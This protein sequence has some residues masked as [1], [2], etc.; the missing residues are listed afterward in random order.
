MGLARV[1]WIRRILGLSLKTEKR[2]KT[3]ERL[4][5]VGFGRVPG[6]SC[7]KW[8]DWDWPNAADYEAVFLNCAGLW[9]LLNQWKQTHSEDPDRFPL[10]PFHR[11]SENLSSMKKQILDIIDSGR[12]VFALATPPTWFTIRSSRLYSKTVEVYDWCPL[13]VQ[14][15]YEEGQV[16]QDADEQFAEYRKQLKEWRFYFDYQPLEPLPWPQNELDPQY[17]YILVSRPLFHNLSLKALGIELKYRLVD[18][19][20]GPKPP[21]ATSGPIYLLH[22]PFGGDQSVALRSLVRNFCGVDLPE[23]QVPPWAPDVEAPRGC[24]LNQSIISLTSKIQELSEQRAELEEAKEQ[25]EEWRKLLYES[26]DALEGVVF[27]ALKLLG[28]ENVKFGPKADHDIAGDLDG[29]TLVFEVKGL[30]GPAGRKH[31][32]D[33]DRHITEFEKKTGEEDAKGVLVANAFRLDPPRGRDKEGRQVFN[34][35]AVQHAE[36]LHFALLDSRTLYAMVKDKLEGNLTDAT[37]ELRS[38]LTT[39]GI[40]RR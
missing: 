7:F 32:F 33:L 20:G 4:L 39:T 27:E 10:K 14:I 40:F 3:I 12:P 21:E 9:V 34:G 13:P 37:E 24:E 1:H 25:S 22:L 2:G 38:L 31:V 17:D 5:F 29:K 36:I 16:S 6:Y 35:D 8:S 30:R 15:E 18:I 11:L 28:L 19:S 26:G 23:A